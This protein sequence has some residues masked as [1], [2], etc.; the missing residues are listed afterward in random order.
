[1]A[2]M[3]GG[4]TYILGSSTGTLYVG[5]TN[6]L[7]RR[8]KEHKSGNYP[9]FASKY[10][11][12]RLLYYEKF[13]TIT[14]AI[15]REKQLKGKTRAKK[16]AIIAAKN[17][18]FSDLAEQWGWLIIGPTQSMKEV[19]EELSKRVRLPLDPEKKQHG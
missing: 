13:E 1:M 8:M 2:T 4:Y 16:L 17:P 19:D 3:Q 7:D 11:C 10:G 15:A 18:E 5:V 12:K 6:D 9:G 14:A